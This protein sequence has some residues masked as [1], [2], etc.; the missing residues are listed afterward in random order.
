MACVQRVSLAVFT[1][2]SADMPGKR[3]GGS[4][5]GILVYSALPA[6]LWVEEQYQFVGPNQCNT[7]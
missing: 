1:K 5:D 2:G 6:S 4:P 3:A 7:F